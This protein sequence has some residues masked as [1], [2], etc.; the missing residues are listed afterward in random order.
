LVDN[1][2]REMQTALDSLVAAEKSP[3]ALPG[4]LTAEQSAYNAC[5]SWRPTS[6]RVTRAQ[7][8]RQIVEVV[9]RISS[10]STSSN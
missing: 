10:S 4:A 7:R 9:N 1:V 2:T 3:A 5:S 6:F 8:G